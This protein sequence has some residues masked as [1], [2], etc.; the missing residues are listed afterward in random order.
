MTPSQRKKLAELP[1]N[2]YVFPGRSHGTCRA[3]E[4]LGYAVATYEIH[5]IS[6]HTDGSRVLSCKLAYRRTPE[7]K[8][9]IEDHTT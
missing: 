4:R 5:S 6:T 9:F 1:D 2:S 3:L 7:G 8:A